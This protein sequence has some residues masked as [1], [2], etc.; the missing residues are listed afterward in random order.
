MNETS[1]TFNNLLTENEQ[2]ANELELMMQFAPDNI[3][4]TMCKAAS[5]LRNNDQ[6]KGLGSSWWI[7]IFF[8][9]FFGFENSSNDSRF[10]NCLFETLQKAT[11]SKEGE[12]E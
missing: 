12:S 2:I 10:L 5:Q 6:S 8:L 9:I 7:I 11:E 1:T 4:C 3:K